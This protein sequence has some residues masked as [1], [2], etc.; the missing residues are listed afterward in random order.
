MI[1]TDCSLSRHRALRKPKSSAANINQHK[2][3]KKSCGTMRKAA[4]FNRNKCFFLLVSSPSKKQK[5]N[6]QINNNVVQQ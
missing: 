2:G 6:K 4:D 5:Q 1:A 3:K